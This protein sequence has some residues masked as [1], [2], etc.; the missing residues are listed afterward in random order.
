M[1]RLNGYEAVGNYESKIIPDTRLRANSM[2]C[3]KLITSVCVAVLAAGY[4]L[5]T[6]TARVDGATV[7][8]LTAALADEDASIRAAA[9]RDLGDERSAAAEAVPA[10]R[11]TLSDKDSLVRA[12]AARA[13]GKIGKASLPAVEE[14]AQMITDEDLHV[15]REA[16]DAL[17]AIQ[18]PKEMSVPL[19]VKALGDKESAV[20]LSALN[21][22]AQYGKEAVPLMIRLLDDEQTA[23]WATLV[24]HEIGPEAR[25]AVPKLNET[26]NSDKPEVRGE[27]AMALG[28]IG[29]DAKAAVEPLAKLLTDEFGNVRYAA[30]L[31][32]GKLG[33]DAK[34]AVDALRTAAAGDD[35]FLRVVATWAAIKADPTNRPAKLAGLR[36][37]LESFRSK[38]PRVRKAALQAVADLKPGPAV[39]APIYGRL[40]D[41][42]DVRLIEEI[43]GV[44]VSRGKEAVPN[45]TKALAYPKI[46][47]HVAEVLGRIGPDAAPAVPALIESLSDTRPEVRAEILY[48]LGSIGPASKA[49]VPLAIKALDDE[50][51]SVRYAA[52]YAL[53][54][55]AEGSDEVRT[56]L[57]D[58]IGSDDPFFCTTCAWALVRI[59]PTDPET[60]KQ[61]LPLLT[62]AVNHEETFVRIEAISTLGLLGAKAKSALPELRRAAQDDNPDVAKAAATAIKA[63][64]E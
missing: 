64:G 37:L 2:R 63:I 16:I 52:V 29:A 38:D 43:K 18:P 27:A 7:E 1:I 36:V 19:M 20:V 61:A 17:R 40:V 23:Y 56:A 9:A 54:R 26:L 25:E 46:R 14:L 62:E 35:V 58:H 44:A 51:P 45:L 59:D 10:L 6:A 50:H 3:N 34:P 41:E 5:G 39:M 57:K 31:A 4:L 47:L 11:K 24:L 13:L 55:I 21:T 8:Q 12:H 28:E 33:A 42:G 48:A 22:L 49:A 30:A 53:G 60:V 15:R 32:L